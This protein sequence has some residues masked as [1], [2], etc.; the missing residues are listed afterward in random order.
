MQLFK[1]EEEAKQNLKEF[2]V[3]YFKLW[4]G[5]NNW[6]FKNQ[7]PTRLGRYFVESAFFLS[8]KEVFRKNFVRSPIESTYR[9]AVKVVLHFI[10]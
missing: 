7:H 10:Y 4:K 5:N 2:V 6:S 8:F 3:V 9:T 1:Q